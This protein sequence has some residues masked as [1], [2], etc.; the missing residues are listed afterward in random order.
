[1]FMENR[2]LL[3]NSAGKSGFYIDFYV[4]KFGS[5]GFGIFKY[6]PMSSS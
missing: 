1:M 6:D 3:I 2:G 4:K 5:E